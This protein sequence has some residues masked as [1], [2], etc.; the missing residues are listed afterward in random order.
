MQVCEIL[1]FGL[2]RVFPVN[3]F[4]IFGYVRKTICFPGLRDLDIWPAT[5]FS[6]AHVES[7]ARP[8]TISLHSTDNSDR[9]D[10]YALHICKK[11]RG[12]F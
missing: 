7:L 5:G 9:I 10:W 1:I 12:E 11:F 4:E 8:N 3:I 6:R 2:L